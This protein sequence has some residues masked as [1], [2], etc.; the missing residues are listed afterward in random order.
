MRAPLALLA[1][2]AAVPSLCCAEGGSAGARAAT[3]V[4]WMKPRLTIQPRAGWIYDGPP[5]AGFTAVHSS[6][7]PFVGGAINFRFLPRRVYSPRTHRPAVR[8]VDFLVWL[9]HHPLLRV[10]RIYRVRLG[11]LV[12]KVLDGRVIAADKR[13]RADGYCGETSSQRPCVPVTADP[14]IEG[15]ISWA[16]E[17]APGEVFR[18]IE[19]E[20]NQGALAIEI[21]TYKDADQFKLAAMG[22]LSTLHQ[23]RR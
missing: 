8:G 22:V 3:W 21:S 4:V 5:D 19:I 20:T 17:P 6:I 18:I 10:G 16:L 12:G 14:D 15:S 11:N 7:G 2:I 23:T 13:A 1:V 9:Q